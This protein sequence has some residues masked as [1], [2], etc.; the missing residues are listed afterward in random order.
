MLANLVQDIT[1]ATEFRLHGAKQIPHFAR[2]LLK[3]QGAEAH[4]QTL[5]DGRKRGWTSK[6]HAMHM[7]Q[8]IR[9]PGAT[10]QFGVQT[11]GWYKEDRKV[12]GVRRIDVLAANV[13]C[14]T[15]HRISE[16]LLRFLNSLFVGAILRIE[17]ALVIIL[18]KLGVDWQPERHASIT[19]RTR[20]SHC[21]FHAFVAAGR[22]FHIACQLIK[23]EKLLKD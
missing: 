21:K 14:E 15:T 2:T 5:Q 19:R 8:F 17:Q 9:K 12:R 23:R 1:K 10:E 3:C 18:W 22:G 7:V 4:L 16:R 11:F 20:H 6:H 13:L